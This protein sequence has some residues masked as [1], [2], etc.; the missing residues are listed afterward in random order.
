M[1]L[2]ESSSMVNSEPGTVVNVE[3]GPTQDHGVMVTRASV[4]IDVDNDT[5]YLVSL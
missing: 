1:P 4:F 5:D 2:V 3:G